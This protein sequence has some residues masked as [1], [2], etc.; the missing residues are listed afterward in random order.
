MTCHP[1]C[2]SASGWCWGPNDTQCVT[3]TNF[4][5]NRQ[6]VPDCHDFNAHG[7]HLFNHNAS[8]TCLP[9]HSFCNGSCAGEGPANCSSCNTDFFVNLSAGIGKL[10]LESCVGDTYL[11]D[12]RTSGECLPC[13]DGCTL[14]YGCAGPRKTFNDSNGC[15]AC[16]TILLDRNEEQMECQRNV[17]CPSGYYREQLLEDRG[18]FLTGTVLCHSCHELCATCSGPSVSDC[19]LCSFIRGT[20]GSCV[21]QCDPDTENTGSSQCFITTIDSTLLY[22]LASTSVTSTNVTLI[23]T[24][25]RSPSTSV[26][27]TSDSVSIEV[28]IGS[29]IGVVIFISIILMILFLILLLLR[30]NWKSSSDDLELDTLKNEA[31]INDVD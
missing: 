15:I 3:C 26:T 6:C 30:K 17:T 10:C 23:S 27:T 7:I 8:N 4:N 2:S 31:S 12:D 29:I 20:N 11:P 16:D 28:V 1:Q 22:T 13:F 5:F 18:I 19:V 25:V 24:I 9:C 14:G 21:Y